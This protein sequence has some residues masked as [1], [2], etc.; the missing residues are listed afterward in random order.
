MVFITQEQ[1]LTLAAKFLVLEQENRRLLEDLQ[2]VTN[3]KQQLQ[4]DFSQ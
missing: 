2:K 1:Y 4:Y 3:E